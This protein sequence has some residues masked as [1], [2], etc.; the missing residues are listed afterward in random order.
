MKVRG[1]SRLLVAAFTLVALYGASAQAQTIT[2]TVLT[3]SAV[4]NRV[5]VAWTALPGAQGYDIL[6]GT[7]PVGQTI[8]ILRL[9]ASAGTGFVGRCT[10]RN[11]LHSRA[12]LSWARSRVPCPTRRQSTPASSRVCREQPRP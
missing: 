2:P 6:V 12:R 7:T 3:A 1:T 11:V 8:A 9:P 4:G 5:T 10:H